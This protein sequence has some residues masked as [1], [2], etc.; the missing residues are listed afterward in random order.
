VQQPVVP[1]L[2][3]SEDLWGVRTAWTDWTD[4]T[5]WT[6]H[7]FRDLLD[8]DPH[9]HDDGARRDGERGVLPGRDQDALPGGQS[10]HRAAAHGHRTG[11]APQQQVPGI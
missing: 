9:R 1:F 5:D 8:R 2:A 3:R 6:C 10:F 7:T 11:V 4:W